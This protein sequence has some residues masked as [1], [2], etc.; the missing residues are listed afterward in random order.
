MIFIKTKY[1]I[2]HR[3][4]HHVEFSGIPT[5]FCKEWVFFLASKTAKHFMPRASILTIWA[6]IFQ[7]FATNFCF[8]I[9]Y[10]QALFFL[11]TRET[12]K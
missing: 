4:I 3:S 9:D 1:L 2:F 10:E 5:K 11:A 12:G 7:N 8:R 6:T